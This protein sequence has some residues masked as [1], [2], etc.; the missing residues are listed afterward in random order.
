MA[1]RC[2]S[3]TFVRVSDLL[4]PTGSTFRPHIAAKHCTRY[5]DRTLARAVRVVAC[6]PQRGPRQ[7]SLLTRSNENFATSAFSEIDSIAVLRRRPEPICDFRRSNSTPYAVTECVIDPWCW[8]AGI[9]GT[10]YAF[11]L[12]ANQRDGELHR[13]LPCVDSEGHESETQLSHGVE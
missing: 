10:R 13:A 7:F 9:S 3:G 11:N 8:C 5:L 12:S 4:R 1:W 2:L 6:G